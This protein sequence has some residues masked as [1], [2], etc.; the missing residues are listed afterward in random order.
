MK[1]KEN[2]LQENGK[3]LILQNLQNFNKKWGVIPL[4]SIIL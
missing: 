2:R 3:Q 4:R 1:R